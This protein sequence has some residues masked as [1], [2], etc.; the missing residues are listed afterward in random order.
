MKCFYFNGYIFCYI[1]FVFTPNCEY[2]LLLLLLFLC[3]PVT[4]KKKEKNKKI[5]NRDFFL[6]V[7]LTSLCCFLWPFFPLA[8]A[9]KKNNKKE[10][11]YLFNICFEFEIKFLKEEE[12]V[13]EA[14]NGKSM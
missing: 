6:K 11:I 12:L 7:C 1:F 14:A 9:S 5:K 8:A 3:L 10:F 4:E 13:K 2:L